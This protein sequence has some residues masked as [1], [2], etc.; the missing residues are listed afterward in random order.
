MNTM[1]I[2]SWGVWIY[3]G[4]CEVLPQSFLYFLSYRLAVFISLYS[5]LVVFEILYS[6]AL[7]SGEPQ[8][9]AFILIR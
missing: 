9:V 7:L 2:G 5:M 3:Y 1:Y 6:I 8:Q 4:F